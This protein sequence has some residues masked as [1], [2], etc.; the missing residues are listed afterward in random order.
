M[1]PSDTSRLE[2]H[3]LQ[4]QP[5]AS[6]PERVWD[7][8]PRRYDLP[9]IAESLG[10][11]GYGDPILIDDASGQ[12]VAGQ[13]VLA[14]LLTMQSSGQ[15]APE[16]IV[17]A[18]DGG[19][20]VPCVHFRLKDGESRPYSVATNRTQELGGWQDD[21]LL[22]ILNEIKATDPLG[23]LGTGF[24]DS[25]LDVL[26]HKAGGD[27]PATFKQLDTPRP[28]PVAAVVPPPE[29]PAGA[30]PAAPAPGSQAAAPVA[31]P[32][33]AVTAPL[34]TITRTVTCPHCGEEFPL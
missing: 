33:A 34:A 18:L 17:V 9:A 19:W 26:Q 1:P 5:L 27:L 15:P 25:D 12:I 14:A 31:A 28:D 4:F 13:G 3:T 21:L 7:L 30:A 8:N 29:P 6:L 24:T 16:R 10:K 11:F 23:L 22:D 32:G 20:L 2:S